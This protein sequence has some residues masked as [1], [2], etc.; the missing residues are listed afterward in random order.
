[1]PRSVSSRTAT[2]P[3][4]LSAASRPQSSHESIA[5]AIIFVVGRVVN[6][7]RAPRHLDVTTSR[8]QLLMQGIG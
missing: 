7:G 3:S 8:P 6:V 4:A 1:M 2:H 5:G